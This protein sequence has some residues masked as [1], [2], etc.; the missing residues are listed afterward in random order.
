M[1]S[2]LALTFCVTRAAPNDVGRAGRTGGG[3]QVMIQEHGFFQRGTV[4]RLGDYR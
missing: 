4:V 3:W 2:R 1:R